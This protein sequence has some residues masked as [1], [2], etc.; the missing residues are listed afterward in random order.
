MQ[1]SDSGWATMLLSHQLEWHRTEDTLARARETGKLEAD[2]A[3]LRQRFIDLV[4]QYDQLATNYNQ[5]RADFAEL[6]NRA[7]ALADERNCKA[8]VIDKLLKEK[9]EREAE[10]KIMQTEL[11]T[12]QGSVRLLNNIVKRHDPD[13]YWS[14]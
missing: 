2:H 3:A 10:R 7:L 12:A 4:A 5:L 11:E 13:F 14:E 1:M 6:H 8:Q 9:A